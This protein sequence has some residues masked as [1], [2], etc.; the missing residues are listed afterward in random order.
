M[1]RDLKDKW[2][3]GNLRFRPFSEAG[4]IDD[5]R[6]AAGVVASA[7]FTLMGEA[8]YLRCPMLAVP[9]HAQFE[10]VLNARYLQREGYGIEARE[11]DDVT[12]ATFIE[13]LPEFRQHLVRYQ[14]DGNRDLLE[15]CNRSLVASTKPRIG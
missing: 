1:R 15:G 14:Q 8:V 3:E 4:F 11:L 2:V 7:G 13:R 10:Q 5:L 6:T 9:L 12:I